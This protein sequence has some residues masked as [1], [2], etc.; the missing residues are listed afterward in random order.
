M[1]GR[2]GNKRHTVATSASED[3]HRQLNQPRTRR[4]GLP[5]VTERPPG[6]FVCLLIFKLRN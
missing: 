1:E 5:T 2:G 6:N 3:S 4:S